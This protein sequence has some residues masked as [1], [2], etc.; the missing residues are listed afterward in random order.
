MSLAR[1]GLKTVLLCTD[2]FVWAA[3]LQVGKPYADRISVV[4]I[5]HP[6]NG[7]SDEWLN[8]ATTGLAGKVMR[9]FQGHA[10]STYHESPKEPH[11][12]EQRIV[13]DDEDG[14]RSMAIAEGWSDGLPLVPPTPQR[15]AAFLD[16]ANKSPE[17][18]VAHI[19]PAYGAATY[20]QIAINAI[21][22][23]CKPEY[24][25]LVIAAVRAI[26]HPDFRLDLIQVTTSPVA[27]MLIFNGPISVECGLRSGTNALGPGNRAN[28]SIGRAVRLILQNIGGAIPGKIDMATLGQPLKYTFCFAENETASPWT[29]LAERQKFERRKN[30]V[31][32]A[33][34]AGIYE[35]RDS[36]SEH[37]S[38]LLQTLAQSMMPVGIVGP[39]GMAAI[40]GVVTLIL[41]P[42]HAHILSSAGLSRFDVQES[43]WRKAQIRRGRLSDA[44]QKALM[45]A[46]RANGLEP[47]F[48]QLPLT[49]DPERI[50]IVVAGGAGRKSAFVPG[51]GPSLAVTMSIDELD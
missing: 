14:F 34:A 27:V 22:A 47:D 43:L 40:D 2:Q 3:H 8:Q 38:D 32:V 13:V 20:Q 36:E 6:I 10:E 44:N 48:D 29:P 5:P 49:R 4:T 42:E 46:R 31:T 18:I 7:V 26:T 35:I 19:S 50:L 17:T 21:M 16:T 51:W 9:S 11:P 37:A 39:S 23:G 30:A 15:V 45:A 41:S 33:P 25:P 12:L 24:F 28:A 1:S